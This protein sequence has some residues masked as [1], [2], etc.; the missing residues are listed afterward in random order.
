MP[1]LHPFVRE[2]GSGPGVVC[3]HANSSNSGQWR[4]LMEL[5]AGGFHVLAADLFGS[6][7]SPAWPADR[8]LTLRDEVAFLEPVFAGAGDPVALVGHSYGAAVALI[9]AVSQPDRV[10]ALAVYEP[11][12][13]SFVDA[14]YRTAD[15]SLG[16]RTNVSYMVGSI[17]I[18]DGRAEELGRVETRGPGFSAVLPLYNRGC[19]KASE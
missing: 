8:E 10:R 17:G 3:L 12:L 2:S 9:A 1:S 5:L 14:E 4:A 16:F 7:Q 18:I 19:G 11:V 6:G 15:G 13:F